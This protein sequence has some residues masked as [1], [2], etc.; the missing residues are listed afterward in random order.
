MQPARS[1]N[2]VK[3]SNRNKRVKKQQKQRLLILAMLAV[4]ALLLLTLLIFGVC[5]IVDAVKNRDPGSENP[6]PD[7]PSGVDIVFKDTT[8]LAT[9]IHTGSLIIVNKTHAYTFPSS[10]TQGF[11][12][13][14]NVERATVGSANVYQLLADK[15]N[16]RAFL[17][18]KE[19]FDAFESMMRNY[20]MQT[21]DGSVAI[22]EAYRSA[23]TQEN[24]E[25]SGGSTPAGNSDHHTGYLIN[26]SDFRGKSLPTDHWIYQNCH[27]YGFVVRYP[28]TKNE[29]TGVGGYTE[30]IRYVGVAHATYMKEKN[31][32]LEEYIEVL[33]S[34]SSST[35][36]VINGADG[37]QYAVY[38][39]PVTPDVTVA[40]FNV[41]T[42]YNYEISGDNVGGFVVTVNLSS[43]TA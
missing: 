38:Y 43:P 3:H 11:I 12:D 7:N 14:E 15:K 39:V 42:N 35:P 31:L 30:C 9:E 25:S 37:N 41:P 34:Y 18:R 20:Y 26:I 6:N 13:A 1:F 32:C 36:L 2:T 22:Y 40:Q 5:S 8:G 29:Q 16:Q 4:V 28:A 23:D 17:M 19:A 27:K 33:K 10:P 24:I 21:E